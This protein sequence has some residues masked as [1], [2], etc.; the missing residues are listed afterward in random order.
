MDKL[1]FARTRDV[2]LPVRGT[3]F[4]A[5]ID[6]FVPADFPVTQIWPHHDVLIPLGLKL[7]IP[8]GHAL[9]FMNKSGV[10]TKKH[11]QVGACVIDEDYQGEPHAHLTNTGTE[12]I[13]IYPGDKIVQ[14]LVLKVNYCELEEMMSPEELQWVSNERG[15]GGFGSL[16]DR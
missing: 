11:L 1:Q 8:R 13:T 5:G 9:I 15:E 12:S 14:G 2:K 10:A 16:G 7:V 4:S 6:F 3:G